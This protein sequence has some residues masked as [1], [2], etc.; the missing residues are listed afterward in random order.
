MNTN[1]GSWDFDEI[2]FVKCRF[3]QGVTRAKMGPSWTMHFAD[4]RPTERGGT[5]TAWLSLGR[6]VLLHGPIGGTK[7]YPRL[8][9]LL[10]QDRLN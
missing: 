5:F 4:L 1:W 8:S 7:H 9:A 6:T 2:C 3:G 10:A